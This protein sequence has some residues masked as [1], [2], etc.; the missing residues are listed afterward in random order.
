M[1]MIDL[2]TIKTLIKKKKL[3]QFQEALLK[4]INDSFE[5]LVKEKIKKY[6]N[7]NRIV[8]NDE[9]KE[10]FFAKEVLSKEEI[11]TLP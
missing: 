10:Q 6:S 3:D 4:E 1:N 8:K 5:S 11:E 9:S 7:K 2:Q